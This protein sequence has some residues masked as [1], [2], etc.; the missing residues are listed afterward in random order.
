MSQQANEPDDVE[1]AVCH[2]EIPEPRWKVELRGCCGCFLFFLVIFGIVCPFMI[3]IYWRS[4]CI[5]LG[6]TLIFWDVTLP[7]YTFVFTPQRRQWGSNTCG[8]ISL[9][10]HV[11][12][13]CIAAYFTKRAISSVGYPTI[14]ILSMAAEVVLVLEIAMVLTL[15]RVWKDT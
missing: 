9:G 6:T 13:A 4:D 11:I 14:V 12:C 10:L 7:G 2:G 3:G 15:P 8:R 1:V 5:G